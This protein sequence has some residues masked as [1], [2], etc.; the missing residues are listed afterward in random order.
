MIVGLTGGIATGKSTFSAELA[1]RGCF[2]VDADEVAREVVAPGSEGLARIASEFGKE[3]V[4]PDGELDRERLGRLVFADESCRERLNAIVHPRVR[5]LMWDSLREYVRGDA[6]RIGIADIPLL[7]EGGT[8]TLADVT[9]LIYAPVA[10]QMDRLRQR[11]NLSEED[12][13]LR[14]GAQMP[15]E[16]KRRLADIVV[17]N[18]GSAEKVPQLAARLH[19]LLEELAE[20]GAMDDGAYDRGAVWR[21]VLR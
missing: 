1:R 20:R 10:R 3:F 13:R 14:I 21:A 5:T 9:V 16:E 4:R 8:H 19:E 18:S 15:I 6:R 7:F 11:S 12:A 17:D 2:L